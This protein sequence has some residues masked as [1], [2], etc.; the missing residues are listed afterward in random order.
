MKE[1]LTTS[2][3]FE[4]INT[5]QVVNYGLLMKFTQILG[6]CRVFSIGCWEAISKSI[7]ISSFLIQKRNLEDKKMMWSY[8]FIYSVMLSVILWVGFGDYGHRGWCV[9]GAHL[10]A[11][12][13]I[14]GYKTRRLKKTLATQTNLF[15][16]VRMFHRCKIYKMR[17]IAAHFKISIPPIAIHFL[18]ISRRHLTRRTLWT[19]CIHARIVQ[20]I[21]IGR[22][23]KLW[24][25]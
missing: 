22:A 7:A 12:A 2:V 25:I 23:M 11:A 13:R 1:L 9:G 10:K 8:I 15:F 5:T 19:L 18:S 4:R 3:S 20:A 14:F 6:M 16:R 24:R 21:S 17:R